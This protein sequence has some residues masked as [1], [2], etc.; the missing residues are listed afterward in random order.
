MD[1]LGVNLAGVE[2]ILNMMSRLA[3]LQSRLDEMESEM[4]S[5]SEEEEL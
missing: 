2:V 5:N 1:E 3:E 4:M